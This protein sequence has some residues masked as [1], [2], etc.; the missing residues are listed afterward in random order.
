MQLKK[1]I[2]YLPVL[3]I[4]KLFFFSVSLEAQAVLTSESQKTQNVNQY[5]LYFENWMCGYFSHSGLSNSSNNFSSRYKTDIPNTA[6]VATVLIS[7]SVN[8]KRGFL[9]GISQVSV[10]DPF[11]GFTQAKMNFEFDKKN[12]RYNSNVVIKSGLKSR[13]E[14]LPGD[15]KVFGHIELAIPFLEKSFEQKKKQL[16]I[17]FIPLIG[18]PRPQLQRLH[19][20]NTLEFQL[21]LGKYSG[22]GF[23]TKNRSYMFIFGKNGICNFFKLEN[24][25]IGLRVKDIKKAPRYFRNLSNLEKRTPVYV[26]FDFYDAISTKNESLLNASF[27]LEEAAKTLKTNTADLKR[28]L[29]SDFLTRLTSITAS[30]LHKLMRNKRV[31]E[32]ERGAILNFDLPSPEKQERNINFLLKFVRTQV[33]YKLLT[34]IGLMKKSGRESEI[35]KLDPE[36][37]HFCHSYLNLTLLEPE[38][39][40]WQP[41][42][43]GLLASKHFG[44]I[45]TVLALN[46]AENLLVTKQFKAFTSFINSNRINFLSLSPLSKLSMMALYVKDKK[47]SSLLI[48]KIIALDKKRKKQGWVEYFLGMESFL[49]HKYNQASSHFK[50]CIDLEFEIG[51][52]MGMFFVCKLRRKVKNFSLF[53]KKL[54][55]KH[56]RAV[57]KYKYPTI[58]MLEA[59][60]SGWKPEHVQNFLSAR[61]HAAITRYFLLEYMHFLGMK[62]AIKKILIDVEK[63]L[64]PLS[65]EAMALKSLKSIGFSS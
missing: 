49:E 43:L 8:N 1:K 4:L 38:D 39:P 52:S 44:D 57:G 54:I 63:S 16:D 2:L 55:E 18:I 61:R 21:P 53:D 46:F 42:L 19:L 24:G 32:N 60:N 5:A 12:T 7:A 33:G 47:S 6:Q 31:V 25:L 15:I 51:Y 56:K 28:L 65:Y 14:K 17:G 27:A 23:A 22:L 34:I 20:Y 10:G 29:F 30:R 48:S 36:K 13:E 58:P 40:R 9:Q 11:K 62:T 35:P 64:P 3:F 26:L 37:F 41:L 45:R 59:I 50:K